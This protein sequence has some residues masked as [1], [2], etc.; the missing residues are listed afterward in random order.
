EVADPKLFFQ[1]VRAAFGQRRKTLLNGLVTLMGKSV[2]K[3]ALRQAI[4]DC[5]MQESI[6]GERL[7]FEEFAKL[8]EKLRHL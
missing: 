5:G 2:S 4:V 3:D 6:R 1:V 8:T 7:S